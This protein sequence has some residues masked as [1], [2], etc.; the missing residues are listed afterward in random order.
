[1]KSRYDVL[2]I[3]KQKVAEFVNAELDYEVTQ[4]QSVNDLAKNTELIDEEEYLK[5]NEEVINET[6]TKIVEFAGLINQIV[7]NKLVP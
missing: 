7:I 3:I 1:M 2:M 6:N 5:Q 4:M